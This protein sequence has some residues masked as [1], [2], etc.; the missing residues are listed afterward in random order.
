[1]KFRI[2]RSCNNI[3]DLIKIEAI[4]IHLNQGF[5]F[6][7]ITPFKEVKKAIALSNKTTQKLPFQTP[8]AFTLFALHL[9]LKNIQCK[10]QN[11]PPFVSLL[12]IAPSNKTTQRLQFKTP[13]IFFI[14]LHLQLK[15]I[16]CKFYF[17]HTKTNFVHT[18][19][20][21]HSKIIFMHTSVHLKTTTLNNKNILKF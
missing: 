8:M 3:F 6:F 14:A 11:I 10:F 17:M 20:F 12:F 15:N 7:L 1:M 13:K 9:Q 18:I 2:L 21:V 5:L 16:Q 19:S 4:Y